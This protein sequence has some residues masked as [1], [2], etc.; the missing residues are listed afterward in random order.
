MRVLLSSK[1]IATSKYKDLF[2]SKSKDLKKE[3]SIITTAAEDYKERNRNIVH[4]QEILSVLGYRTK[5]VDVELEGCGALETS[6]IIVLGGGNPY[7]LLYHLKKSKAESLLMQKIK[8]DTLVVGISAGVFALMKSVTIL[9]IL[10]PEMNTINLV[11]K[12]GIGVVREV[13]IPHYDRFV[14]EGIIDEDQVDAFEK[15]QKDPV[16]RLREW[17]VIEYLEDG[18]RIV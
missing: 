15:S 11:D 16:L 6:E 13:V 3:V 1:G 5:L 8:E 7:Y 9:D 14:R 4:L 12:T 2:L 10:T 17:D 18:F